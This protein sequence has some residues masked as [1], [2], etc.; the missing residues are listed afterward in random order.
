M[1]N[2]NAEFVEAQMLIR[3][4]VA[5][6]FEAFIDPEL[7]KHFWFTKG[8]GKLETGKTI[9]WEWEMYNV[10]TKVVVKEV[11]QNRKIA[12]AWDEPATSVDFNFE[13]LSE[14]STYVVIQ[15]Y[16]FIQKDHELLAIIKDSTG[17]FTTV[18]DGLKAFLEHGINLN[19]IADK[20]P[21]GVVKHGE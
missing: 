21:K 4:P 18:L 11:L 16:G 20:F 1:E 7:T 6:V 2:K 5:E 12:I 15:H 10:S 8:S 17:G 14:G 13:S 9:M 19:L 3:K